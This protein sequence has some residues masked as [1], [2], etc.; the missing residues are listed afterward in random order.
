MNTNTKFADLVGRAVVHNRIDTEPPMSKRALAKELGVSRAHLYSLMKA[1]HSP[2]PHVRVRLVRG[3]SK[4]TGLK[5]GTV[6]RWL[7]A[8]WEV[9]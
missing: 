8:D 4:L 7:E 9:L 3:F 5:P 6:R 2:M 1:K